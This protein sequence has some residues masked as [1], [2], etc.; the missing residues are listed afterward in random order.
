MNLNLILALFWAILCVGL[1]A[2][3]LINP[4][5][6]RFT[7]GNTGI[8]FAW[9]A[10]LFCLYN[11]ARWWML[12]ARRRDREIMEQPLS[13]E[14]SHPEVRNPEFDFSDEREEKDGK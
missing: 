3:P 14:R 9:V 12:R 11:L 4:G 5:G 8:P 2:Y 1:F 13:R 6:G 10:A 7:I